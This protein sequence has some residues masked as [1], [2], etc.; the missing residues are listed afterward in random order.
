MSAR[1]AAQ[2]RDASTLVWPFSK[3]TETHDAFLARVAPPPS[4]L[5]HEQ[6]SLEVV[7]E[8]S[9]GKE[10]L[11][12]LSRSLSGRFS[13]SSE[14]DRKSM[15]W[16]PKEDEDELKGF[17]RDHCCRIPFYCCSWYCG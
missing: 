12:R 16:R 11:S 17:E 3:L 1:L 4:R 10:R 9:S 5:S 13:R 14:H 8:A 6:L 2:R 15:L 7:D